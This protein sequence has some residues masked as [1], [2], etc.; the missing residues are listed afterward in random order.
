MR[1]QM[2]AFSSLSHSSS[3]MHNESIDCTQGRSTS[4]F[5]SR[6]STSSSILRIF[7]SGPSANCGR[8]STSSL[9]KAGKR[10]RRKLP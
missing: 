7:C 10:C 6:L 2:T 4:L 1:R 3:F 8:P 9:W 5:G